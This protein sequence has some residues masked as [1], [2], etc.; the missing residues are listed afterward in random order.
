MFQSAG[1]F[2]FFDGLLPDGYNRAMQFHILKIDENDA[3]G[4]LF[5]I[6][7]TDTIGAVRMVAQTGKLTKP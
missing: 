3:L 4:L 7:H 2:P 5:A 1:L 6:A